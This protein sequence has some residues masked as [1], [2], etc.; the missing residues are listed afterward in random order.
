MFA[1]Q[2]FIY[3]PPLTSHMRRRIQA[4]A[5]CLPHNYWYIPWYIPLTLIP[6][7]PFSRFEDYGEDLLMLT[8]SISPILQPY[9]PLLLKPEVW[10][11]GSSSSSSSFSRFED[12]GVA[13]TMLAAVQRHGAQGVYLWAVFGTWSNCFGTQTQK[14]CL[15]VVTHKADLFSDWPMICCKKKFEKKSDQKSACKSSLVRSCSRTDPD[16]CFRKLAECKLIL[17]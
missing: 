9:F 6:P 17:Y 12:Y 5:E 10:R 3:I 14:I 2:L 7:S 16:F 4:V 11:H 13:L 1:T 15:Q 8:C